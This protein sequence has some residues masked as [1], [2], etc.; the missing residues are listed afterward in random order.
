[1]IH[2]VYMVIHAFCWAYTPFEIPYD[3]QCTAGQKH[4]VGEIMYVDV[5]TFRKHNHRQ[6]YTRKQARK[7]YHKWK[8]DFFNNTKPI[9]GMEDG[10]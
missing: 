4:H 9:F 1:M 7:L 6:V 10:Q 8:L 5:D 2:H 3:P